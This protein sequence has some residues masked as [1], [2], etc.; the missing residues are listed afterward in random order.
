MRHLLLSLV[1]KESLITGSPSPSPDPSQQRRSS[2][3]SKIRPRSSKCAGNEPVASQL[4]IL[5]NTL[6]HNNV[7]AI[8]IP[9]A[10]YASASDIQS[11]LVPLHDGACCRS[12]HGPPAHIAACSVLTLIAHIVYAPEDDRNQYL[13][14]TPFFPHTYVYD[15]ESVDA[16]SPF[17]AWYEHFKMSEEDKLLAPSPEFKAIIRDVGKLNGL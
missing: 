12:S 9:G 14:S 17:W 13:S 6:P 10:Q 15:R 8:A 16:P 3:G 5:L 11:C 2:D 1:K 7:D 4:L